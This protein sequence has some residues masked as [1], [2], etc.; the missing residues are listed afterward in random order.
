MVESGRVWET[1]KEIF[2]NYLFIYSVHTL[3]LH[4]RI[5]NRIESSEWV[6]TSN[7]QIK[8]Q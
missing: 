5:Q 3:Q 6:Q 4:Q 1:N 2:I 8:E 7:K